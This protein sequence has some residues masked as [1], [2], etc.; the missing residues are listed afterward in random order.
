MASVTNNILS[1]LNSLL[2][3]FFIRNKILL[4]ERNSNITSSQCRRDPHINSNI[5]I[6]IH[7]NN[8]FHFEDATLNNPHLSILLLM[9][10]CVCVCVCVREREREGYLQK[11]ADKGISSHTFNKIPLQ[12]E[13]KIWNEKIFT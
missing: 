6:L 13:Q 7:D 5:S 9:W 12:K 2:F 11:V 10:V 4:I 1:P 3:F 8:S